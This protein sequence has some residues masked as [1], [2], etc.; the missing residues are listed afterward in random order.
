MK[1]KSDTTL[2]QISAHLAAVTNSSQEVADLFVVSFIARK[3]SIFQREFESIL[4]ANH[5]MRERL[6]SLNGVIK[7]TKD[8]KKHYTSPISS[9]TNLV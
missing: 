3:T 4:S 9:L 1:K 7:S 6:C 8:L 2:K 5:E